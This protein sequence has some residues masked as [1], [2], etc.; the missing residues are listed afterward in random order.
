MI[1]K[2]FESYKIK[3]ELKRSGVKYTFSRFTE[4]KFGERSDTPIEVGTFIGLW[5][6]ENSYIE[7]YGTEGNRTRND[8]LPKIL[9][10]WDEVSG[11]LQVDD[12]IIVNGKT[13]KVTGITNVQEWN[14]VC[15]ISLEMVDNG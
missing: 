9:C 2:K 1:N 7:I 3:R 15:D 12:F 13:F 6:E 10:L 14:I 4:N 5:H 11:N 8:K